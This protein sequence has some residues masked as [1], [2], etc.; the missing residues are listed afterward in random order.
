MFEKSPNMFK[1]QS[2][3]QKMFQKNIIMSTG[4][5]PKSAGFS[6]FFV[7]NAKMTSPKRLAM[8][9]CHIRQIIHAEIHNGF[10]LADRQDQTQRP[11]CQSRLVPTKPRV[12]IKVTV[13]KSH[14]SWV[15]CKSIYIYDMIWLWSTMFFFLQARSAPHLTPKLRKIIFCSHG[16]VATASFW[17]QGTA[18]VQPT[19]W[20][21]LKPLGLH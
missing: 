19:A 9:R 17:T 21:S 14:K 11:I 20:C 5:A 4:V 12:S 18:T 10:H 1:I 8:P 16:L 7:Q 6:M 15:G 2:N 3:F 13:H